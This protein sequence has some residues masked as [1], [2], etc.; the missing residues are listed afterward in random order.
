VKRLAFTLAKP[1]LLV[2]V[3]GGSLLGFST[4]PRER[5]IGGYV[6]FVG[7]LLLFGLVAAARAAGASDRSSIYDNAL[8]QRKRPPKRPADL[9]QLE[10]EVALATAS[11]FDVHFRLRPV[12]REIAAHRLASRRGL[13]LDAGSPGVRAALGEELWELV[14]PS[15]PPPDDRLGPGL[16]LSRLRAALDRL[17]RI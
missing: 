8:T 3:A 2:G 17:E 14:R 13:E 9:E 12:L 5:L 6:L 7:S 15:R 1:A 11:S 10:R 16:A 4:L